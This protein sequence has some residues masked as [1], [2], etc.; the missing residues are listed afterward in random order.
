MD[1]YTVNELREEA[2]AY[3]EYRRGKHRQA[4]IRTDRNKIKLFLDWLEKSP[5]ERG[6]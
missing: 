4:T 6:S 3:L 5:A 2:E 1:R